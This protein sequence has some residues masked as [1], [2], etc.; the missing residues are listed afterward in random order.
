MILEKIEIPPMDLVGVMALVPEEATLDAVA[1]S[2]PNLGDDW[3]VVQSHLDGVYR[4]LETREE[5]TRGIYQGTN[6][7]AAVELYLLAVREMTMEALG[8]AYQ[9]PVIVPGDE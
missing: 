5:V 9:P 8:V 3:Q 2:G 6:P 4:V 1:F 7:D